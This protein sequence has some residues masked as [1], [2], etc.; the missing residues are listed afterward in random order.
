VLTASLIALSGIFFVR[1][2]RE[3]IGGHT[4]DTLGAAAQIAEIST[5]IALAST[6]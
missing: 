2:C 1:L 4:G 3:K 5:L 6:L